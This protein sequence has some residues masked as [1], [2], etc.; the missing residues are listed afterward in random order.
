MSS[1]A[2]S[3]IQQVLAGAGIASRRH[4][5]RLIREGRI[6][7][8]GRP[9]TTLGF[10]IRP[11]QYRDLR[12]DGQRLPSSREKNVYILLHKPDGFISSTSDPQGR[13]TVLDLLPPGLPRLYP[14]G[15]LDYHT[16]GLLLLTNDGALTQSLLHPRF[17]VSKSYQA[18]VKGIP[19]PS[20]LKLL[21]QGIGKGKERMA[22]VRAEI[23]RNGIQNAWLLIEI[24]QGRYRQVRRMCEWI[25]HPVLKLKRVSFGP[26]KLG[27]LRQGMWRF[28]SQ[29]EVIELRGVAA[30]A[31]ISHKKDASSD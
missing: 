26:I 9:I 23:L 1:Q 28:L 27:K 3:R 11:D 20:D 4:S 5:E 29:Q 7:L 25:G 21:C 17:H 30:I 24:K 14:V 22:A 13:P 8:A 15:R 12:I 16:E 6:T 18:K 2:S 31:L 19:K 10:K